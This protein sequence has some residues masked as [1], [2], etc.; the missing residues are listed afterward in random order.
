MKYC[1]MAAI[2]QVT[3]ESLLTSSTQKAL[4]KQL[5]VTDGFQNLQDSFKYS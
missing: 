2:R 4:F 1:F 5:Y 3:D